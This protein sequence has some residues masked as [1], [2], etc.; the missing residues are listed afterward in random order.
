LF[1]L[2]LFVFN[3]KNPTTILKKINAQSSE[4]VFE[5]TLLFNYLEYFNELVKNLND[6]NSY[7]LYMERDNS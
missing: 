2:V 5:Q 1:L 3:I 4:N 6:E 7:L